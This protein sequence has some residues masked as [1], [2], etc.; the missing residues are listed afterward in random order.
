MAYGTTGGIVEFQYPGDV[1]TFVVDS[2]ASTSVAGG[3]MVAIV[4][5][6]EVDVAGANSAAVAGVALHD[7]DAGATLSVAR[8]GIYFLTAAGTI[9]AGDLVE[10]AASGEVAA[11]S[12]GST[13]YGQV[14]GLALEDISSAATGRVA[15]RLG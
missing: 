7:A 11:H 15:L 10:C 3:N 12:A 6:M 8:V 13:E 1:T 9:N 5:D 14:I 2:S 4:G